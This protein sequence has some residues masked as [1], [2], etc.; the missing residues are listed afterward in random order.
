VSITKDVSGAISRGFVGY[1]NFKGV[2]SRRDFW[3]WLGLFVVVNN[4]VDALSWLLV[5]PTIAYGARRM[6]DVGKSGWWILVWPVALFFA[7]RP[8]VSGFVP[9]SHASPGGDWISDRVSDA[10]SLVKTVVSKFELARKALTGSSSSSETIPGTPLIVPSTVKPEGTRSATPAAKPAET[11][12]PT[13]APRVD[14]AAGPSDVEVFTKAAASLGIA[15][16]SAESCVALVQSLLRRTWTEVRSQQETD[17]SHTDH[18]RLAVRALAD[19]ASGRHSFAATDPNEK[20]KAWLWYGILL[21]LVSTDDRGPTTLGPEARLSSSEALRESRRLFESK[22]DKKMAGRCMEELGQLGRLL[23]RSDLVTEGFDKAVELF[24]SA[25]A[26][27]R[28]KQALTNAG[29]NFQRHSSAFFDGGHHSL[30][31]TTILGSIQ[32][33]R[34][35]SALHHLD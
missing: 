7:L 24:Q 17:P 32:G 14:K 23:G 4:V 2:A 11:S 25:G 34:L 28:A 8:S 21:A 29:S 26:N 6:H 22:D 15:T 33:E 10:Q 5:L 31:A 12:T 19:Y 3:I 30:K 27:D 35:R 1:F 9:A 18:F 13:A 20:A 16:T